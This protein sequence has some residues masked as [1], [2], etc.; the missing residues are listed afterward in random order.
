MAEQIYIN[1]GE[2]ESWANKFDRKNKDMREKLNEIQNTVNK[3]AGDYESD[4]A[5]TTRENITELTPR[6]EQY[7]QV[8]DQYVKFIRRAAESAKSADTSVKNNADRIKV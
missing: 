4:A 7:Q 8:V 2:F 1:W 6:L 3:T 5:T